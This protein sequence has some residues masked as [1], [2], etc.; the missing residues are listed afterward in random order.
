[1]TLFPYTTLFRSQSASTP[2][3]PGKHELEIPL[4]A[5]FTDTPSSRSRSDPCLRLGTRR[6]IRRSGIPAPDALVH[7][8]PDAVEDQID[9]LGPDH[10]VTTHIVVRRVLLPPDH[11]LPMSQIATGPHAP[12]IKYFR[13]RSTN[14]VGGMC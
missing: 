13:S 11:L 6:T 7:E 14:T 5:E 3:A 4:L 2:A 12:F 9:E 1:M 10:V 8:I